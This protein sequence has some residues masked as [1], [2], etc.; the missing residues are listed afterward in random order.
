MTRPT[1]MLLAPGS[2]T[3]CDHPSLVAIDDALSPDLPV[4]R[5][6]FDY[7]KQGKPFPDRAPKLIATTRAEAGAFAAD[8]AVAPDS[9]VLGGRSMGGRMCSMAVAEG[10]P[11]AG[12]VLI[13]YPLHPPK[14]PDKLRVA[15]FAEL[16][17][18]VCSSRAPRTS[19][20]RPR[21]STRTSR[22]SQDP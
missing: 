9:L 22:R 7:R 18:R 17:F 1:G 12:L 4:R 5:F 11:A 3:S 15:H 13:C 16:E 8:L 6:D 19:S 10:L 20:V 2:G 14:K 21:S